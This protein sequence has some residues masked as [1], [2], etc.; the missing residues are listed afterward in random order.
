MAEHGA[1]GRKRRIR[2]WHI[3]VF[4]LCALVVAFAIF[5][6]VVRAKINNRLD[7]VRAAGYPV[8]CE[9][10]DDWYAIAPFADNAAEYITAAVSRMTFPTGDDAN[11]VP[12]FSSAPLPPRR[13][14][15]AERIRSVTAT[16]MA[17][18]QESL[19]LLRKGLSIPDCRYPVNFAR[20]GEM[21]NVNFS[22]LRRATRLLVLAAIVRAEQDDPN[23]AVQTLLTSYEL[24]D[25]L[26]EMPMIIAELV[27]QAHRAVTTR[28]LEQ[29]INRTALTDE[30][31][32]DVDAV[33]W[34]SYDPNSM[35]RALA[36][37][38]CFGLYMAREPS[39]YGPSNFSAALVG[40]LKGLG[41]I[42]LSLVR[43]LDRMAEAIEIAQRKPWKRQEAIAA[44]EARYDTSASILD[45]LTTPS[46]RLIVLTLRGTARV[47]VAR[48][49]VAVE[50]Y[51]LA[52]GGLPQALSD[53]VPAYLETVPVD[54]FDGQPLRYKKRDPGYVLYSIGPD[55]TDNNGTEQQPKPRGQREELPYDVTFIVER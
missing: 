24:A 29:V 5:R 25:T 10:L 23:A 4:I 47:E 17:E 42:D 18:N 43:H 36:G 13:E 49:A 1:M 50:R 2:W 44:A 37:E 38:R 55:G 54:P 51:R 41:V 30:Q 32:G 15:L 26:I 22:A 31:L 40:I 20:G 34:E 35:V 46:G 14:P 12:L 52:T 28:G 6:I 7:A 27:A 9:E 19:E 21:E 33:L 16:M 8:T 39:A 48:T 11:G 53:L 45:W 3:P